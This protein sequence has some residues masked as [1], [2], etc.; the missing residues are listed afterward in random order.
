[1]ILMIS[2][3]IIIYMATA[4]LLA[5]LTMITNYDKLKKIIWWK[6]ILF[7][8]LQPI[9]IIKKLIRKKDEDAE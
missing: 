6:Q 1:M 8:V 3:L 2:Q 5:M 4:L 7:F 9:L